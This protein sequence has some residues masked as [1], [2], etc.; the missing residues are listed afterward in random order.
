Y[1]AAPSRARSEYSRDCVR[2]VRFATPRHR[3]LGS[4][5][6]MR[7]GLEEIDAARGTHGGRVGLC[8][9]AGCLRDYR[10]AA[11]GSPS[12]AARPPGDP[13]HLAAVVLPRARALA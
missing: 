4:A 13:G 1:I 2:H 3:R 6:G 11:A 8:G 9:A 5:D 7:R 10:A 12:A